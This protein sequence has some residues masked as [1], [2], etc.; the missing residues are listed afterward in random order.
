MLD[1]EMAV[2]QNGFHLGEQRIIAVQIRPARLHH[3][4]LRLRFLKIRNGAAQKIRLR[5]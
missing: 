3:A 1:D 5:E 2:E 4:D